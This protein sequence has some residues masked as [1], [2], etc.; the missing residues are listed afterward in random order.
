M[1]ID[2]GPYGLAELVEDIPESSEPL[3]GWDGYQLYMVDGKLYAI[4]E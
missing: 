4:E 2:V 1:M 3:G